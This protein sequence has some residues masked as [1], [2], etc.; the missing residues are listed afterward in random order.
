[1]MPPETD[2][3]SSTNVLIIDDNVDAADSLAEFL[4]ALGHTTHV[5][6]DG[7]SAL[8]AASRIRPATVILDIGMPGM[9]GYQVA[10]RL[11]TEV[12]LVSS[13]LIAVSGYTQ[14]SD[15]Q[16]A[17]AAGFDHHFAKPL[18]IPRLTALLAQAE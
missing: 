5:A 4:T 2:N 7:K 17:Q 16:A 18:D 13:M 1:M 15:R 14:E 11:R 6:Y 10:R 9:N 12:G 8:D 3:N